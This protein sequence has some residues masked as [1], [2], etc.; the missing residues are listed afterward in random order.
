MDFTWIE[1]LGLIAIKAMFWVAMWFLWG[2]P[3]P[4]QVVKDLSSNPDERRYFERYH[5]DRERIESLKASL[6]VKTV[7][8]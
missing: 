3:T 7:R 1:T 4:C 6:A 2:G 8:P 5:S